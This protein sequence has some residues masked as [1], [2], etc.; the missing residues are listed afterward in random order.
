MKWHEK[1]NHCWCRK[2]PKGYAYCCWCGYV[3][4]DIERAIGRQV[5]EE[6]YELKREVSTTKEG[7]T[8]RD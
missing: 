4:F 8:K 2:T 1:C 3:E 6:I 5:L 7:D